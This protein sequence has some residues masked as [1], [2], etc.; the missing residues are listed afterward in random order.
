[1]FYLCHSTLT[2]NGYV[3]VFC[4]HG[5]PRWAEYLAKRSKMCPL[6]VFS[7][8]TATRHCIG[9]QTK[10]FRLLVSRYTRW[11]TPPLPPVSTY[12]NI[13]M[14][15]NSVKSLAQGYNKRIYRL[16][17]HI[18]AQ[19]Q[20]GKLWMTKSLGLTRRGCVYLFYQAPSAGWEPSISK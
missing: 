3:A 20:A 16:V 8:D 18:N 12:L 15:R 10:T 14:W 1:M 13:Q 4:Q 17:P 19:Y 9:S 11:P 6:S 2:Q 5:P 7:K